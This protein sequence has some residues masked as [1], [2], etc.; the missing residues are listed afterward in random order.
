MTKIKFISLAVYLFIFFSCQQ[1]QENNTI[2]IQK[3]EKQIPDTVRFNEG[4]GETGHVSIYW[5]D[6]IYNNAY[7]FNQ[8]IEWKTKLSGTLNDLYS[9]CEVFMESPDTNVHIRN[10]NDSVFYVKVDDTYKGRQ[11]VNDRNLLSIAPAIRPKKGFI[12][13]AYW[14]NEPID[15]KRTTRIQEKTLQMR[16]KE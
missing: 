3:T 5:V 2:D 15:H 16:W 13:D 8:W 10:K 4:F 6:T 14:L 1:K 12:V 11:Y 9:K 7:P